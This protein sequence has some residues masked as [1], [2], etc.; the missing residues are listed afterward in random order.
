MACHFPGR[1]CTTLS[2]LHSY[3]FVV[4]PLVDDVLPSSLLY[5]ANASLLLT[6]AKHS[7]IMARL[8]SLLLF[9]FT[10]LNV[11]LTGKVPDTDY[12]V[13]I[14]GGG[15]AGLS[16]L[17]ALCRV[18]RRAILFDTA[19]YRNNATRNMHDVIGNDGE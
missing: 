8:A 10:L 12:D 19:E 16:A 13:I 9:L 11:G 3:K 4:S 18:S 2:S 17:S 6:L 5:F 14:V 7:P 1:Y 15:P